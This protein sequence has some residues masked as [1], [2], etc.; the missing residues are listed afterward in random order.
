MGPADP[1]PRRAAAGSLPAR[2]VDGR[3]ARGAGGPAGQGCAES[4]DG[5]GDA[6]DGAMAGRIRGL[7]AARPVGP[8]LRLCVGGRGLPAGAHGGERRMHAS[9][10]LIGATPEGKKELVGFQTGVRESAQSWRELL[11]DIKQRKLEIAPDLAV[12]DGALG[13]WKAIEE[14][15][16]GTRH[17]RCWVHKTANVLNKVALSVQINMKADLREIYGAPTRAAADSAIDVF[18]E[19]YGAS[20]RRWSPA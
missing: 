14:V 18:A 11:V 10:V 12:G 9:L 8:A 3:S 13:F 7:G 20:T 16:P 4:V 6:A 17:Q 15:F 5:C 1:Q 2:G 19:K